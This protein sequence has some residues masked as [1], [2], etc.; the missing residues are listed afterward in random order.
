MGRCGMLTACATILCL[1]T[2]HGATSDDV[3]ADVTAA[4]RQ[5]C[6]NE[7]GGDVDGPSV[8]LCTL[9]CQRVVFLALEN[10]FRTQEKL[11]KDDEVNYMRA[12]RAWFFPDLSS[13]HDRT[14]TSGIGSRSRSAGSY[15]RIGR[16]SADSSPESGVS[17]R[18]AIHRRGGR[19][20]SAGRYLR[21]GRADESAE[22][23]MM[24]SGSADGDGLGKDVADLLHLRKVNRDVPADDSAPQKP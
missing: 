24:A 17:G 16:R 6:S 11:S 4:C 15:L 2:F 19:Q 1:F 13:W 23:E 9:R 18:D 8:H 3:D 20:R 22:R 5:R 21:I 10:L 12:N 7:D 14:R